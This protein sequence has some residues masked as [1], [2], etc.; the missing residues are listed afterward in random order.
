MGIKLNKF[1]IIYTAEKQGDSKMRKFVISMILIPLLGMVIFPDNV[2]ACTYPPVAKI[3][4]NGVLVNTNDEVIVY[5]SDGVLLSGEDSYGVSAP[6]LDQFV[7]YIR[8]VG[9]SS[10]TVVSNSSIPT[11]THTFTLPNG[12]D[13][14]DY[15]IRLRVRDVGNQYGYKTVTVTVKRYR[16]R[17]YYL[18]DHLGSI[19]TTVDMNGNVVGYD[20]Y[21]PFGLAM[22][23]RSV[24]TSNPND[25]Y[26]FT[27]YEKDD[28]GFAP[29]KGIYHANARGY[30][31][32]LGR[33]MQIDPLADQFPGWTPYHYTHNNPVRYIDPLGTDTVEVRQESGDLVNHMEAKGEDV[34]FIVD[35]DGNRLEDQFIKFDEGTLVSVKQPNAETKEE[36]EVQ[37]TMFRMKG[38]ENSQK[39]F[40]F[41][42][43]PKNT[44]VEWTHARIGTQNSGSNIVGTHNSPNST[45][46][47]HYL[48]TRNYTL[49]E[50]IHN[51]PGGTYPS[52]LP[53][54]NRGDIPNAVLYKKS[55][56]NTTL[57]V[58]VHP[59]IYIS[60]DEQGVYSIIQNN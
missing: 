5:S 58:Y 3:K 4:I 11:Y 23:E 59:R 47:G 9:E 34:F 48:R 22:P 36:G 53:G 49:R 60:Y 20:D 17:M 6:Y 39:L 32:V 44:K 37:L 46:V 35:K 56:V 26:K 1:Y 42:S 13:E 27:G 31:P 18:K 33:F 57:K 38:D 52:G 2:I 51:H 12:E 21:Y 8:E 10:W 16:E 41:F 40:E 28:E 14:K 43:D 7:W 50:V 30:D 25:D 45:A 24:N 29:G 55:N 15:E 54:G 19:R